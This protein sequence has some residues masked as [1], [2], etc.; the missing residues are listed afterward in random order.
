MSVLRLREEATLTPSSRVNEQTGLITGVKLLGA[1]SQ[2]GRVYDRQAMKDALRLYE[3]VPIYLGHS[4]HR[5]EER[6]TA[7]IGWISHPRLSASGDAIFG[8]AHFLTKHP[9]VPAILQAAA[10][11]PRLFGMSHDATGEGDAEGKRIRKIATVESCDVVDKPASTNGFFESQSTRRMPMMKIKRTSR[12]KARRRYREDQQPDN[13][14]QASSDD[15]GVDDVPGASGDGPTDPI[16]GAV[17][18]LQQCL[19][20]ADTSRHNPAFIDAVKSALD[21]L[22]PF[23]GGD[24]DGSGGDGDVG[25]EESRRRRLSALRSGSSTLREMRSVLSAEDDAAQ[26]RAFVR[27]MRSVR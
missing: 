25:T 5:D 14:Q 8:D 22:Q 16:E 11:N 7:K 9:H 24:G 15:F 4:K 12:D 18:L 20:D 2:N 1:V 17:A 19:D 10:Q 3:N 26:R 27:K 6:E 21:A 13:A 23:A